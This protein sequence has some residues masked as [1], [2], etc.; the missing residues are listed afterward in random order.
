MK[1][2]SVFIIVAVFIFMI[3]CVSYMLGE[4][5]NPLRYEP[6]FS[7]S[8]WTGKQVCLFPPYISDKS[9]LSLQEMERLILSSLEN[10]RLDVVSPS[11]IR[12]MIMGKNLTDD[13][14]KTVK[15]YR[16]FMETDNSG[17]SGI[18]A[19]LGFDYVL[20]FTA[21]KDRSM[22]DYEEYGYSATTT[23]TYC[24]TS[25]KTV[26]MHLAGTFESTRPKEKKNPNAADLLIDILSSEPR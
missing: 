22:D 6:A 18:A 26:L 25:D 1:K 7:R 23:M 20:V 3:S 10:A 9:N 24:R 21:E 15:N 13:Y 14:E 19:R 5:T 16:L 17:I 12:K 2:F 8:V 4:K 11:E